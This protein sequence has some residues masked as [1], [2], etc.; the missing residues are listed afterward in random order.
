MEELALFSLIALQAKPILKWAGGKTQLLGKLLPKVPS[1][2]GKYIEP[3]FGGGALFFATLP[4]EA[5]IADSNPELINVYQQ[6]KENVEEVIAYLGTYKNTERMYYGVRSQ[7]WTALPPVQAA[8]RTIYLN[9]TCWG[10]LYRVN[11]KGVFNAP[12]GKYDNPKICDEAGLLAA[13]AA[14]QNATI[15]CADYWDVLEEYARPGDFVYLDPPCLPLD[16]VGSQLY[17]KEQFKEA[18]HRRLAQM[19]LHLRDRGCHVLLTNANHPLLG[20]LFAD[21]PMDVVSSSRSISRSG[22]SRKGEDMIVSIPP[23]TVTPGVPDAAPLPGQWNAFPAALFPDTRTH[24]LAAIWQAASRFQFSTA[25]DLFSGSG[26]VSYLF[27]A[28]G[29]Q[30][31]SCDHMAMNALFARAMVENSTVT[32]SPA[33]AQALL[34]GRNLGDSFVSRAFRGLY[35]SEAENALIDTLRANI[36]SLEEQAKQDIAL[37]ALIR[38]CIQK[39]G[40]FAKVGIREGAPLGDLFLEEV[41]AVN[42][43]VFDNGQE[44]TALWADALDAAGQPDLLYLDPPAGIDYVR[45]Y[46]LT[47][48][49]A[50]NWRGVEIQK[51]SRTRKFKSYPSAFASKKDASAAYDALFRKYAGSILLLSHSPKNPV[52][53]NEMTAIMKKYK[54][55]VEVI[56]VPSAS[57]R[58]AKK[59]E[60]LILGY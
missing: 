59:T 9:R 13:S 33:E 11:S 58:T 23:K 18:D 21:F 43:A 57:K 35:F 37:A 10:G 38:A 49:L 30:I 14:L 55:Q 45:K 51:R 26:V 47:E 53:L 36:A 41:A 6:V 4:K 46:H 27:K 5:I 3:F 39:Q 12:Y 29:K 52:P 8:A 32:L 40:S 60:Y 28:Q 25:A 42:R 2:K 19:V 20:Q 24:H 15:L 54:A 50:R 16:G 48:G 44:N 22:A 7:D 34:Q 17:T 31:L 56:E 1:Y